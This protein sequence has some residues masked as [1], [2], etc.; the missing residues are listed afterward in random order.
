MT[1]SVVFSVPIMTMTPLILLVMHVVL[2]MN[3]MVVTDLDFLFQLIVPY[4]SVRHWLVS[5]RIRLNLTIFCLQWLLHDRRSNN[6]LSFFSYWWRWSGH[7]FYAERLRFLNLVNV[8]ILSLLEVCFLL[9]L[10]FFFCLFLDTKVFYF[11]GIGMFLK[12]FI[13]RHLITFIIFIVLLDLMDILN[14]GSIDSIAV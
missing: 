3:S 9:S 13:I 12:V 6:V 1:V 10:Q 11:F 4:S 2:I 14:T 7:W 5:L 8:D